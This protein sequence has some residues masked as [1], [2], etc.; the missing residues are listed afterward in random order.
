MI[1]IF[2]IPKPFRGD[3]GIRQQNALESWVRLRPECE[4]ILLG[5]EAGIEQ[6]SRK[7]GT[8]WIGEIHR[9]NFGTPLLND[10]FKKASLAANNNILCYVNADIILFDDLFNAVKNIPFDRFLGSS[11]RFNVDMLDSDELH[12]IKNYTNLK[13]YVRNEVTPDDYFSMDIFMFHK[14][15]D[16]GMPAFTVG[17]P[18]WDQWL[19]FRAR[20]L[21]IPVVDFTQVVTVVHQMHGYKH[22]PYSRGHQWR[23][24]EGDE[25]F[26]LIGDHRKQFNLKYATHDLTPA[27][28]Q[29]AKGRKSLQRWWNE[30]I[31]L[32]P[33]WET[34]FRILASFT[35]FL[36]NLVKDDR[37]LN[38]F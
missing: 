8:K 24:P 2:S 6:A 37:R 18:G 31:I 10:A 35:I 14:K 22:V 9:N 34:P 7:Y 29:K 32:Y 23:G 5:D 1:S 19:I 21:R 30:K 36:R 20:E 28:V 12:K 17:R 15:T 11:H 33:K 25:N 27:G 3:D 13:E 38:K 4:I 16:F 26:R